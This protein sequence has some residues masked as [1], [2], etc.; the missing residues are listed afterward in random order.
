MQTVS[1]SDMESIVRMLERFAGTPAR[2]LVEYNHRRRAMLLARK[3]RRKMG[4]GKNRNR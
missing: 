2:G 4:I 1:D 3:L